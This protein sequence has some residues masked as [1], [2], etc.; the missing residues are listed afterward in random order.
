M[1]A[2]DRRFFALFNESGSAMKEIG[3][4]YIVPL[5][6]QKPRSMGLQ[7]WLEK[8]WHVDERTILRYTVEQPFKMPGFLKSTPELLIPGTKRRRMVKVGSD[9]WVRTDST[10]PGVVDVELADQK[11]P[12]AGDSWF[13]LTKSEWERVLPLCRQDRRIK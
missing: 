6:K 10:R 1:K 12:G 11:G 13:Q 7:T 5:L 9:L 2:A 3:R 8:M 4:L